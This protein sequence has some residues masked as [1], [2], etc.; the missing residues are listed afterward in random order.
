M[1][2]L[3]LSERQAAEGAGKASIDAEA[4]NA[5]LAKKLEDAEQKVDQLQESVQRFVALFRTK[6]Y[7]CRVLLS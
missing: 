3:L 7:S 6:L 2:A 1:Q 4:R 5:E